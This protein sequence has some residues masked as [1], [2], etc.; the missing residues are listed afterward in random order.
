MTQIE[1]TLRFKNFHNQLMGIL[2]RYSLRSLSRTALNLKFG[3]RGLELEEERCEPDV[4]PLT[5]F[6][7]RVDTRCIR[8]YRIES[9]E[10]GRFGVPCA[11]TCLRISMRGPDI[12][13]RSR[14]ALPLT[15]TFYTPSTPHSA[16]LTN[17]VSRQWQCQ[18]AC[19]RK[20][21]AAR[22]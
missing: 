8:E 3:R 14:H 19:R 13:T 4:N 5:N 2:E 6:R 10:L 1:D 11:Q 9:E 22:D 21:E 20:K 16:P 18:G 17:T 15:L 12:S 7:I